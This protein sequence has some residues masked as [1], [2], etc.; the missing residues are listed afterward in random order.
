MLL[1][2]NLSPRLVTRLGSLFPGLLHVRDLGLRQ[3][4]DIQ[5]WA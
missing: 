2:E 3:A 4:R 1:D 5:I